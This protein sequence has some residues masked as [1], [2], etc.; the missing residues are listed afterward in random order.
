MRV[1]KNGVAY[2]GTCLECFWCERRPRAR[3]SL[4]AGLV[5]VYL[6]GQAHTTK[7]DAL[8]IKQDMALKD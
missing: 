6:R 2:I 7:N 8:F 1:R 5:H 3:V 4:C